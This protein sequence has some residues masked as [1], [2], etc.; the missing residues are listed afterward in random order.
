[1]ANWDNLRRDA[2]VDGGLL[3]WP[4]EAPEGQDLLFS[5]PGV[6]TDDEHVPYDWTACSE[7]VA[8]VIDPGTE[9]LIC[10]LTW[11]PRA[12]GTFDFT[13][14]RVDIPTSALD[15]QVYPRGRPLQWAAQI[16]IPGGHH[17]QLVELS[18]FLIR[19]KGV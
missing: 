9:A 11:V 5:L 19:H 13:I 4:I 10:N 14:A 15:P 8:K 18:P 12:D 17:V 3:Q 1:M 7:P 6:L 16:T 2:S